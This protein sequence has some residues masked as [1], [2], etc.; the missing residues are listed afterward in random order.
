M[1]AALVPELLDFY[2]NLGAEWSV[3]LLMLRDAEVYMRVLG[4]A[5]LDAGA[6]N[7]CVERVEG[8][9]IPLFDHF[10]ITP[11][12]HPDG[13]DADRATLYETILRSLPPGS[14][15]FFSLHP[16]APGE[17]ETLTP[18]RAY[19]RTFEYEYLRSPRLLEFLEQEQIQPIGFREICDVLSQHT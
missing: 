2:L 10:C 12:D 18:E 6:W 13:R 14:L 4:V 15:T 11:G 8:L 7:R 3:P 19:W 1:G 5:D 17:I 16:C 9:G